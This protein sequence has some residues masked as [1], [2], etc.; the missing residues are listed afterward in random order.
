MINSEGENINITSAI[1][2]LLEIKR[3]EIH[4]IYKSKISFFNFAIFTGSL[5]LIIIKIIKLF[6]KYRKYSNI[7]RNLQATE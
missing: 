2:I 3:L 7:I 1:P 4:K 5:S 6:K